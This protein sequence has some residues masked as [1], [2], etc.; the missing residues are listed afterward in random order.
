MRG[1]RGGGGKLFG[2]SLFEK[3]LSVLGAFP[4]D[5][6]GMAAFDC[7]QEKKF[8]KYKNSPQGLAFPQIFCFWCFTFRVTKRS[9][10]SFRICMKNCSIS[11]DGSL[12]R[13][14]DTIFLILF[15]ETS[16][17][18]C[19]G[20]QWNNCRLTFATLLF[21]RRASRTYIALKMH[22]SWAS[23]NENVQP[24]WWSMITDHVF[25]LLPSLNLNHLSIVW[26]K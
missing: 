17:W 10:H 4:L 6:V 23:D 1:S 21:M 24:P 15:I 18:L 16:G 11:N 20:A 19:G 8:G 3:H 7:T 2:K 13:W 25:L 14:A 12:K 26:P 22:L 5:S 9:G